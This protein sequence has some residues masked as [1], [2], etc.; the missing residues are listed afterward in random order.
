[1][2]MSTA[3]LDQIAATTEFKEAFKFQIGSA[4]EINNGLL[5]TDSINAVLLGVGLPRVELMDDSI[6]VEAKDGSYSVVTPFADNRICF[7]VDNNFG[8]MIRTY[9]NEEQLPEAGK[10]YSKV[11][12]VSISKYRKDGAEFTESEFNAFPVI[13]IANSMMILATDETSAW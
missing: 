11:N 6:T 7:T 10:S 12:N 2:K 9:A 3:T 1:M 8:E 13:N 4:T 5:S